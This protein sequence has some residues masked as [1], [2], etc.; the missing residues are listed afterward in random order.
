MTE[1]VTEKIKFLIDHFLL[2]IENE[3]PIHGYDFKDLKERLEETTEPLIEL[4]R[5]ETVK[6]NVDKISLMKKKQIQKMENQ[7]KKEK[8][9]LCL[10][11]V[12]DQK[13][14]GQ[15]VTRPKHVTFGPTTIH[16]V[17]K[18]EKNVPVSVCGGTIELDGGRKPITLWVP[19][20]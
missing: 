13:D 4:M 19:M 1:D 15:R 14:V 6:T 7:L 16:E 20:E 9:P 11:E 2:L 17:E 18:I 10:G 12:L 8:T 5:L 3:K